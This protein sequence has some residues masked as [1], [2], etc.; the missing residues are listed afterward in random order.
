MKRSITGMLLGLLI[1]IVAFVIVGLR[2]EETPRVVNV[3]PLIIGVGAAV[4]TWLLQGLVMYLLARSQLKSIRLRDMVRIYLAAAFIGGISPVRGL[5][6]PYEVY[7]LNRVGLPAGTGGAVVIIR[8]MLNSS[9]VVLGALLGL[10]FASGLPQVEQKTFILLGIAALMA[11]A[12]ALLTYIA[13]RTRGRT[14][15]G[16]ERSAQSWRY[17]WRAK[18]LNFIKELRDAFVLILRQEPRLLVASGVIMVLYWAV[19]LSIGPLSLM[20]A[21][22]S[23]DW[24]AVIV[25]Q[26]VLITF[27]LSLAPTPGAS[28]AAELG[29]AALVA[30]HV[31]G[32]VLL[33]G[34]LIWRGL[35]H[36]FQTVVGAFFAGRQLGEGIVHDG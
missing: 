16:Q 13:R 15:R 32:G 9:V 5:E 14:R 10:I 23:G 28:G 20:A 21:G 34:V 24:V 30:P 35:T 7:L 31:P 25:A 11:G 22:W 12:W 8:G 3:W 29:F 4:L 26:M 19:R 33:S 27:V 1:S 18:I 36:F 2:V 6:I 17:R